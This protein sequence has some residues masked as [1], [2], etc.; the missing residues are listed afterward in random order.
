MWVQ[1]ALKGKQKLRS[2]VCF[3]CPHKHKWETQRRV[4]FTHCIQERGAL[5]HRFFQRQGKPNFFAVWIYVDIIALF[6][7]SLRVLLREGNAFGLED[8]FRFAL[9]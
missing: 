6:S 3:T 4:L 9:P 5:L 8:G 1:K 2:H 7:N